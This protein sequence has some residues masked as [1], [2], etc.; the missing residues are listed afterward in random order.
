MNGRLKK[1]FSFILVLAFVA[2]I[3]PQGKVQAAVSCK[4]LCGTVLKATGGSRYLKYSSA[5]ALDF[6]GFSA[7]DRAKVKK[8]QYVCDDKEA[9][10][11]CIVQANNSSNAKSLLKSLQKY[12]KNNCTGGYLSDYTAAE[13]KV[14]KS[15]LCGRKGAYVWY[16]A[17]S[18]K[19]EINKKGQ[20]ALKKA[21]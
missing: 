10:S 13:Q 2:G 17:M 21:L 6:G 11:L 7:V 5:S 19:K 15:A 14:F 1:L 20:N 4:S 12:K 16:I 3:I 9:Y 8:I 18:P